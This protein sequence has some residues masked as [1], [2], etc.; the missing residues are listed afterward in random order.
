MNPVL[1]AI[2]VP[3]GLMLGLLVCLLVGMVSREKRQRLALRR[4]ER[5]VD[6]LLK[7]QGVELPCKLSP[8]VQSLAVDPRQKIAAI[9]LHREQT[10]LSLAEA[11]AE[12]EEFGG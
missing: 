6:A 3:D 8:E 12:V 2:N 5:K 11:K 9:K 1:A 4:V 10:G 7:H